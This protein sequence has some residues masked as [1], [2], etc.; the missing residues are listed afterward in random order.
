MKT[1]ND[2]RIEGI[3]EKSKE[4]RIV[5]PHICWEVLDCGFH[6]CILDT[7]HKIDHYSLLHGLDC[8]KELKI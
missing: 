6:T 3:K 5:A 1:V 2:M 4:M 7:N 8:K